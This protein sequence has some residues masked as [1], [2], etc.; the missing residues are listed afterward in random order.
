MTRSMTAFANARRCLDGWTLT[1]DV[2]SVNSRFLD[3][4]LRLPD[5][6]RQLETALRERIHS[7]L[8]RGK[9]E[10]RVGCERS[11]QRDDARRLA[12][13]R[14]QRIAAQWH[15]VR[16]VLPDT[17]TP[18]LAEVLTWPNGEDGPDEAVQQARAAACLDAADEA[19][20]QLCEAAAREGARLAAMIRVCA[21]RIAEVVASIEQILPDLLS[22]H[23]LRLAMKLREA[24]ETAF[25]VGFHHISGAEL[26]ERLNQESALFALRIDVAEEVSRLRA[27]LAEIDQLLSEANG[28]D[29]TVAASG[30]A[31]RTS[32]GKRLDFLCQ[33]LNREANTLGSKAGSVAVTRHAMELKLLIEQIREQAQ[34]LV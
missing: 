16:A 26:T 29:D 25:P 31:K 19:L 1:L 15:T 30:A 13:E 20:A 8:A 4:H 22:E 11:G 3:I 27:H 34:N 6:L 14:L 23:R 12:P 21:A 9:V 33:E 24:V 28:R 7:Q 17:P 10:M 2:R 32:V 18:T 5:E